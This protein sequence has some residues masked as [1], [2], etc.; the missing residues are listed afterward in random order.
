MPWV[1]GLITRCGLKAARPLAQ[2]LRA[3]VAQ[4][5]V[6]VLLEMANVV[7]QCLNP[8]EKSSL[9]LSGRKAGVLFFSGHRPSTSEAL[10]LG[11]PARWAGGRFS[12]RVPHDFSNTS[13]LLF[14]S[15]R[16]RPSHRSTPVISGTVLMLFIRFR[17][18]RHRYP[19]SNPKPNNLLRR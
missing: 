4:P 9:G 19:L 5:V 6:R 18:N 8:C 12:G 17:V 2:R 15:M 3:A 14:Q 16:T 13:D 10:G 11:L 1:E 7:A